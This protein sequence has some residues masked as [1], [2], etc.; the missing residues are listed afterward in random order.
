MTSGRHTLCLSDVLTSAIARHGD[1]TAIRTDDRQMSYA[2]LDRASDALAASLQRRGIGRGDRVALHLRNCI[3]YVVAEFAILKLC[4]V[5]VPLN[6][7]MAPS[8]LAYCLDHA[9]ARALVRHASLPEAS[10]SAPSVQVTLCAPEDTF[11]AQADAWREALSDHAGDFVRTR[12]NPEDMAV[13]AYTGGTTGRPKGVVHIQSTLAI[14]LLAHVVSGDVRSDEVMLLTTPLPH[15]AGFHMLAC[16]LQ[17]GQVV[18][19]RRFEPQSFVRLTREHGATWTFAVPTMIYRLLDHLKTSPAR[20][21][22]LRTFVYG[23][24]PMSLER[25]KEGLAA[26]G[27]IFLQIYGQTECPN[28][29]TTLTKDDHLDPALLTSCGRPVPFLTIRLIGPGGEPAP[30]G[31]VGEIEIR[32]PY[33]LVEYYRDPAA[34]AEALVAGGLRTGDLGLRDERGYLFLVDRAKDM[35][36]TGG[37]NVYS[38]E[39]ERAL[40]DHPAIREAAV[41]GLPDPDWGERVTAAVTA[42]EPLDIAAIQAFVRARLS[43][44]KSPKTI[45]EI[46]AM[47]LT[48][49][50]K[51]DK[52]ALRTILAAQS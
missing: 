34:T 39:V 52:K 3:E 25:L 10:G 46:G 22:S 45:V 17:G 18:I 26:F 21:P 40:R 41:V 6:E 30:E 50:G 32:S 5:K 48:P 7:L 24:A 37:M 33:N 42:N 12:P 35:I 15:S 1:R 44:Y 16:L 14:N 2:D 4:A 49:Y 13:L 36:I 27:P 47:P 19:A 31:S 51:V 28:F 23:A 8:E 9:Q 38:V 20:T 11:E 43:A 29:V